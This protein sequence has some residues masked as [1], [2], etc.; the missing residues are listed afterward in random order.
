MEWDGEGWIGVDLDGTLAEWNTGDDVNRIGAPINT[1]VGRVKDWVA[2]RIE[3]RIV[4]ARVSSLGWDGF[5]DKQKK[6]IREWTKE[7][8]G[9]A[10]EATA[11]KDMDMVQLWD[12]RAINRSEE[13]GTLSHSRLILRRATCTT[14]TPMEPKEP[15]KTHQITEASPKSSSFRPKEIRTK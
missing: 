3:V 14:E 1:M 12:D 7:H 5:I 4:T 6:M 9:A 8:I 13:H 2:A 15:R 10:L 11:E